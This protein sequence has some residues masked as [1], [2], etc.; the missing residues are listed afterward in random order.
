MHESSHSLS[1]TSACHK[2]PFPA[3]CR[4]QQERSRG[5]HRKV[6]WHS[7]Q[8]STTWFLLS[9]VS[10]HWEP[11]W[12]AVGCFAKSAAY[13]TGTWCNKCLCATE[14][15]LCYIRRWLH[16]HREIRK[17]D[18]YRLVKPVRRTESSKHWHFPTVRPPLGSWPQL[19][20]SLFAPLL[21]SPTPHTYA[22]HISFAEPEPCARPHQIICQRKIRYFISRR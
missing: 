15:T 19:R 13:A 14:L 1:E 20:S 18:F 10:N 6:L 21:A 4:P 2:E 9:H 3:G 22:L 17:V 8:G 12:F 16:L 5:C 11:V 7:R